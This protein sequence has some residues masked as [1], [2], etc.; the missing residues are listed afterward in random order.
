M[1]PDQARQRGKTHPGRNLTAIDEPPGGAEPVTQRTGRF[2]PASRYRHPGDV[3]RLIVSA[4]VLT[5]TLTAVAVAHSR[6]LGR[7]AAALT[8]PGS[9]PAGRPLT[10]L[11][12][13]AF[14]VA[15][16]GIAA[17]ALRHRRFRLLAGLAAA[18]VAAGATLAGILYL[19]GDQHPH[20]VMPF[21]PTG[22]PPTG[23]PSYPGGP[24]CGSCNSETTYEARPPG[25]RCPS[26][27]RSRSE[28]RSQWT[29][30]P[31]HASGY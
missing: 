13:V 24:A 22:S 29:M 16:A 6:L 18:A 10:G 2:L 15:A 14:A 30:L 17:A 19:A 20:A 5:G 8:W 12:Q 9:G 27:H 25:L 1:N 28:W 21:S 23:C 31:G 7:G 26:R 4:L 3:I 11:V